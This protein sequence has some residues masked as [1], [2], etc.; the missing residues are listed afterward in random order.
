[1]SKALTKQQI[2]LGC[3]N[4][5]CSIEYG[6]GYGSIK[7]PGTTYTLAAHKVAYCEANSLTYA[8]MPPGKIKHTC[9]NKRCINPKHMQFI[10]FGTCK[11]LGV[12]E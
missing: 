1:M 3:I 10:E 8:T 6:G 11:K 2:K 9:G 12:S 7:I 5:N 4:H